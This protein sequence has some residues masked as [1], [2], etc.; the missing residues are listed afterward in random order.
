MA[1]VNTDVLLHPVRIKI[2]TALAGQE[3][4]PS[5][6]AAAAPDIPKASLYRHLN[7]LRA[8]GAI[9]E[10]R[11]Y[12]V[13]GTFEKVYALVTDSGPFAGLS[14]GDGFGTKPIG[15]WLEGLIR[16]SDTTAAAITEMNADRSVNAEPKA[17]T[18]WQ[19]TALLSREDIEALGT[20]IDQW[21]NE[22]QPSDAAAEPV[23]IEIRSS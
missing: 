15:D 23:R 22:R 18:R 20:V 16:P 6:I 17:E 1:D 8:C 14:N 7:I 12:R 3:A 2:L 5:D 19:R 4:T 21:L 9:Q 10:V 11:E 13:R